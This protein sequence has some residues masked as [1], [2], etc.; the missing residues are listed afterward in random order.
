[1][2]SVIN[3]Q[4]IPAVDDL[5]SILRHHHLLHLPLQP[6]SPLLA[7]CVECQHWVPVTQH[8]A[9]VLTC[10]GLRGAINLDI[11]CYKDITKIYLEHM[12]PAPQCTVSPSP[13]TPGHCNVSESGYQHY[14]QPPP[15]VQPHPPGWALEH[16]LPPPMSTVPQSQMQCP[17]GMWRCISYHGNWNSAAIEIAFL[18]EFVRLTQVWL[19]IWFLQE[20]SQCHHK[21]PQCSNACLYNPISDS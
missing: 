3:M 10:N 8:Q 1:M 6:V 16:H 18:S 11:I 5:I 14:R 2:F 19:C 20:L 17:P 9:A 15:G 4:H 21:Y 13:L 12:S 7:H